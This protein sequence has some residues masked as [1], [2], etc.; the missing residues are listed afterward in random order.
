MDY[1]EFKGKTI[2]DAITEACTYYTV[3]SDRLDYEIIENGSSGFLGLGAKNAVIKARV[4]SEDF[5]E[6]SEADTE[7]KVS[8]DKSFEKINNDVKTPEK[9]SAKP[10]VNASENSSYDE[11]K[12]DFDKKSDSAP[13]KEKKERDFSNI[14]GNKVKADAEKFIKEVTS[15]MKMNVTMKLEYFENEGELYVGLSG[16]D[17]GVLIGKRGQ[18]LD[19]LQ[20]LTSLVVNKSTDTYI[21]VKVDTE[22]YRRRRKETL[23]NLARNMA[24]KAKRTRRTVSLEPMNPYER[25]VIHSA[26]Q[27]DRY[28]TTNSEGDE[29]YRRVVIHP[30][31]Y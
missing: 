1:M 20:Y 26:L 3:A 9:V 29:P 15:A 5:D 19:S 30:K 10:A 6:T 14:D 7:K 27:S 31:R 21:R 24:S 23:E 13:N 17:M 11:K 16:D 12:D 25:R 2:D 4:K 8:D 28:V 22:D 18:T